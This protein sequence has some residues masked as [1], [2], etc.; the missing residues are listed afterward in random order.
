M[1]GPVRVGTAREC[2]LPFPACQLVILIRPCR[3]L[4]GCGLAARWR[5]PCKPHH[6]VTALCRRSGLRL[7][8]VTHAEPA[9]KSRESRA[10]ATASAGPIFGE[11]L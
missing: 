5:W 2:R 4:R 1:C 6:L 7:G 10:K 8:A 11:F 3:S 9:P